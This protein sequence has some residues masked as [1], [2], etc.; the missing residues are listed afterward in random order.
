MIVAPVGGR[1]QRAI[2][3]Y[4]PDVASLEAA[5]T[6]A[7][8]ALD[9][10]RRRSS[11]LASLYEV[12]HE[13]TAE[14]DIDRIL[15]RIVEQGR[16]VTG[17]DACYLSLNDGEHEETYFRATAGINTEAFRNM[18][19]RYGEGLGG[20]VASEARPYFSNDYLNDP[21]FVHVVDRVVGD[22][23]VLAALGVPLKVGATVLGVLFLASRRTSAFT[24]EDVRICEDLAQHAAVAIVN[25][26][27]HGR[28][29][30][31][32]ALHDR[33]TELA[34]DAHDLDSLEAGI[35]TALGHQV[36]LHPLPWEPTAA[37]DGVMLPIVAG[38]LRLGT[39]WTSGVTV[40]AERIHGLEQAA[41]VAALHM[42]RDRAVTQAQLR[43]RSELIAAISE[44]RLPERELAER[45]RHFGLAVERPHR[46]LAV[47]GEVTAREWPATVL[48][49]GRLGTTIVLIPDGAA[50]PKVEQVAGLSAAAIGVRALGE[51]I[52]EAARL[53][54][55]AASLGRE[56]IVTEG[57]LGALSM[58]VDPRRT[59]ALRRQSRRTLAPL[60]DHD[61]DGE[62]LAT[63]RAYLETQGRPGEAAKRCFVH[64]N[65]LYYRLDRIRELTGWDL[66]D[67]DLR[68][69]LQLA[70]RVLALRENL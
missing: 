38:A 46:V 10:E 56:G 6:A 70:C 1:E 7:L 60:L 49:A 31:E 57:D 26:Q 43:S 50:V 55:V 28:L 61:R 5:L 54:R 14:L 35:S 44:G 11:R 45:A 2:D 63:L 67:A 3:E 39:L 27:L 18:R 20:L 58:L 25:A 69:H 29:A 34:L 68:L 62:L 40:D 48:T 59:E 24:E 36:E 15:T 66:G 21:R 32:H 65:T 64:V 16:R 47:D 51:A 53:L 23:G 42:L 33:L 41:R 12:A 52:D 4:G 17:A 13:L 30:R 8:T 9:D 22:E 37:D 19:L